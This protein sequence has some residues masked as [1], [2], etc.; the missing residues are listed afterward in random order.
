MDMVAAIV[1]GFLVG[2]V[3]WGGGLR[4]IGPIAAWLLGNVTRRSTVAMAVA[5]LAVTAFVIFAI[6]LVLTLVPLML[7]AWGRLQTGEAWRD[8]FGAAFLA[9]MAGY[10]TLGLLRRLRPSTKS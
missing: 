7:H 5:W 1:W 2:F 10:F 4:L 9:S 6:M 8:I 3:G